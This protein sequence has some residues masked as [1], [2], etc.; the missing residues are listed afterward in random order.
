[1]KSIPEELYSKLEPRDKIV[2]WEYFNGCH[3]LKTLSHKTVARIYTGD[4]HYITIYS[5][6]GKLIK[7]V[8][9]DIVLTSNPLEY[10]ESFL[11]K[12]YDFK[13]LSEKE[14]NLL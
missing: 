3:W 12:N 6:I 11:K 14:K 4:D 8:T 1:M 9:V 10:V 7:D 2:Y 5:W 13:F